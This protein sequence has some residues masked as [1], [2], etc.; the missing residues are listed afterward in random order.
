MVKN[1]YLL[2]IKPQVLVQQHRRSYEWNL[3]VTQLARNSKQF[4]NI[5]QKK[6]FVPARKLLTERVH[7][8]WWKFP[9]LKIHCG[10]NL[11]S[12]KP[13]SGHR[14]ANFTGIYI[15]IYR[16]KSFKIRNSNQ[17]FQFSKEEHKSNRK[18][19]WICKMVTWRLSS[20]KK[21]IPN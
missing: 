19:P 15:Y 20:L 3:L 12:C 8:N 17:G 11:F 10:K 6:R 7:W 14:G 4:E 5:Q 21:T 16:R 1:I 13:V 18:K 9:R 2:N